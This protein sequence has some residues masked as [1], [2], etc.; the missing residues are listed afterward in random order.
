MNEPKLT[1]ARNKSGE[2][3]FI[4][5]VANGLNCN[6]FCA[7]CGKPLIA[8]Q[9]DRNQHHFAHDGG[10]IRECYDKTLHSLAEQIIKDNKQVYSPKYKSF[11]VYHNSELLSFVYVEVE[12]RNDY[13]DLQP[14]L[15]GVTE[16]G[17][18]I[19]IE[20]RNTHK[21]DAN[22]EKKL[23]DREQI[24]MEIDVSK[25]TLDGLKDFLL[26]KDDERK[27]INHPEY[28]EEER[29]ARETASK[30]DSTEGDEPYHEM[31][32]D[33][34]LETIKWMS[35]L[36]AR[37]KVYGLDEED[38]YD[39]PVRQSPTEIQSTVPAEPHEVVEPPTI[40]H[41]EALVPVIEKL[42]AERI[43][44]DVNGK[45]YYVDL[46]EQTFDGKYIVARVF[47]ENYQTSHQAAHTV[48]INSL[49][50]I[51]YD[52]SKESG[53]NIYSWRYA[54]ARRN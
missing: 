25:Q 41:N 39:E 27:W 11:Y 7:G 12:Q 8:R 6:C 34:M 22:K 43:V 40:V 2:I 51:S 30:S 4:D 35:S 48:L 45:T 3:V 53:E 31:T 52:L 20:I 29:K 28:D 32:D 5:T 42:R 44:K 9:G 15:V 13:H 18:R 49:G 46:C 50:Y 37:T 54:N 36:A 10:N 47:D 16:D 23:R 14:D 17:K 1:Y 19:H 21:V 33:E 24:C 38:I 26:T